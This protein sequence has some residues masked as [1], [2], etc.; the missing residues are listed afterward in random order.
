M[1]QK[2]KKVEETLG[3]LF[4][5]PGKTVQLETKADETPI[6]PAQNENNIEVVTEKSG[7]EPV[8]LT[9]DE[10]EGAIPDSSKIDAVLN[11]PTQPRPPASEN[12]KKD[13]TG[14]MKLESEGIRQLVVF[15]LGDEAFGLPIDRVESIIKTQ[16]ITVVPHS[17][18]Y[19]VGVTN[20]RGT[21][22]PV[23]DLRRRFGLPVIQED[24]QQRIVVVSH[25]EEKVGLCVDAVSQVLNVPMEA[26]EPPPPLI[27][28]T[29][30]HNT[31]TA[32]AKVEDQIVLLLDLEKVLND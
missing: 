28:D 25:Q 10:P 23:I 11:P 16:S 31:I 13:Q 2:R 7:S 17:R 24:D 6:Q 3:S 27:T 18:S 9:K 5:N 4:S 29:V 20:L 8:G 21:V 1:N 19:V 22:L 12:R 32:I 26:I 14:Q 15:K 30:H